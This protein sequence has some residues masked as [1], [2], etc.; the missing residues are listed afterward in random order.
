M[1]VTGRVLTR[2]QQ[3][4]SRVATRLML[5][6]ADVVA[7]MSFVGRLPDP[8]AAGLTHAVVLANFGIPAVQGASH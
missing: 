2:H 6:Y 4:V 8:S 5:I 3:A 1:E 7:M